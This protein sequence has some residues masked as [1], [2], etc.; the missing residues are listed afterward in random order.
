MSSPKDFEGS[1]PTWC[2]GC[3]DFG[4]LR[5]LQL[6][7]S[8]LGLERK[9]VAIVSGI[10]CSSKMSSYLKAYGFHGIH[11]RAIPA[12]TGVKLANRALTVIAAGGDG[13]GYS[14]GSGHFIHAVRRNVDLT[15]VVMDNGVY[16]LTKG[17]TSPTSDFKF[18]TKSTPF[19][20]LVTPIHPMALAMASGVTFL[21]QGF[22]GDIK[23][24]SQLVK[25]GIEHKGFSHVNVFS[26]C[27]T[28]NK[29]NTYSWFKEHI[30]NLDEDSSHDPKNRKMAIEKV[31]DPGKIY[32]GLIYQEE[33]KPY[34]DILPGFPKE[35][36]A[37]QD[38]VKHPYDFKKMARDE[39]T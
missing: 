25:K 8:E 16:G 5:A 10:G 19:G 9:D 14:I 11:G 34:E 17:Q 20:A 3:G 30:V 39:F 7:L 12:A 31:M 21:A 27:V 29:I 26:P 22:S 33:T 4:L 18:K 15:Y 13:D 2:P 38:I 24:L 37:Q 32:T 28:Y 1:K 6:A 23:Q 35:P 36:I